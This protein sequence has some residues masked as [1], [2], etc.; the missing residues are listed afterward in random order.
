MLS[1]KPT[2]ALSSFTFIKRIFGSYLLSTIRVVSSAHLR[3]L[4]FLPAI[5]IPDCASSSLAF[6]MMYSAY[7]VSYYIYMYLH[8][9]IFCDL[10]NLKLFQ[11]RHKIHTEIIFFIVRIKVV[12]LALIAFFAAI[13]LCTR[14]LNEFNIGSKCIIYINVRRKITYIYADVMLIYLKMETESGDI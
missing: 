12:V 10:K 9:C 13:L 3:L 1:F 5:L 2:F 4:I 7:N 8:I 6:D 14:N 11:N